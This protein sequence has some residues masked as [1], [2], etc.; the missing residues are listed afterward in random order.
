MVLVMVLA[1]VW[2]RWL[3][4]LLLRRRRLLQCAM[5]I[6]RAARRRRLRQSGLHLHCE[7]RTSGRRM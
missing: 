3:R 1:V 6:E 7:G 2:L 4:W 5:V